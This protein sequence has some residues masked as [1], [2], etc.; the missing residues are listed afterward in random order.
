[1]TKRMHV[2]HVDSDNM[3]RGSK[4]VN[5]WSRRLGIF[6]PKWEKIGNTLEKTESI[7]GTVSTTKTSMCSTAA[8][9]TTK[10]QAKWAN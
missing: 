3:L 6:G 10:F 1:M 9:G 8:H 5:G 4:L 2:L 7:D